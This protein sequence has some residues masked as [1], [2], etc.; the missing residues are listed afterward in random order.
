MATWAGTDRVF[1][2]RDGC[3]MRG[4]AIRQA[5]ARAR[6]K[7]DMPGFRF[8]DLRH[9][10]QT[11]A[12]STGATTKDLM[13]RLGHASPA[14]AYRYLHAVDGRDAEIA[15]ALSKLAAHGDAARLPKSIVVKH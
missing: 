7:A 9:T 3:P 6:R 4:D 15:S 1:I 13:R 12:A 11:L 5:F 14:A 2:G 8:H 10:G